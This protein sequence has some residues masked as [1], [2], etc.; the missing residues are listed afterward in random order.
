[1]ARKAFWRK[2]F[3]KGEEVF[4]SSDCSVT[5]WMEKLETGRATSALAEFGRLG[6]DPEED[7]RLQGPGNDVPDHDGDTTKGPGIGVQEGSGNERGQEGG[8]L[9]NHIHHSILG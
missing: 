2:Y 9:V 6:V 3:L 4:S 1:M 5:G 8:D 7:D